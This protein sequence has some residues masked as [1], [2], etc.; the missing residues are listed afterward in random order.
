MKRAILLLVLVGGLGCD[1][2]PFVTVVDAGDASADTGFDAAPAPDAGD[3][4]NG[5]AWTKVVLPGGAE[6]Y[7]VWAFNPT[8][9][10][11]GGESMTGGFIAHWNG[12]SIDKTWLP[13]VSPGL[14]T[15]TARITAIAG[16]SPTEVVAVGSKFA[17]RIRLAGASWI[18]LN[19]GAGAPLD[20]VGVGFSEGATDGG[21][22]PR[23]NLVAANGGVLTA[24]TENIFTPPVSDYGSGL[25]NGL[26][27]NGGDGFVVACNDHVVTWDVLASTKANG[28]NV[29][30]TPG[31]TYFAGVSRPQPGPGTPPAFAWLV[32]TDGSKGVLSSISLANGSIA[33]PGTALP[34]SA[35]RSVA[36][37]APDTVF[38]AGDDGTF[39]RGVGGVQNLAVTVSEVT[40]KPSLRGVWAIDLGAGKTQVWVVGSGGAV[41]RA[42]LP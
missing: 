14:P 41:F 32:G 23:Y 38:A 7:A 37:L 15:G 3:A 31:T 1:G 22:T 11:I 26:T 30:D 6:P 5:I 18:A 35:L 42:D 9:V 29:Y 8:N 2:D 24:L 27:C 16:R 4:G 21:T 39:V 34:K 36:F 17:G 20:L 28:A 13:G 10:F 19:G 33:S 12:A 40:G 25:S